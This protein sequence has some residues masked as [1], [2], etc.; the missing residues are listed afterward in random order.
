MPDLDD[1][2]QSLTPAAFT[3]RWKGQSKECYQDY[4]KHLIKAHEGECAELS[5]KWTEHRN[6]R[7]P[8][9]IHAWHYHLAK[10]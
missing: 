8:R 6:E 7:M 3:R 1:L 5:C 10:N 2:G 4:V 9:D